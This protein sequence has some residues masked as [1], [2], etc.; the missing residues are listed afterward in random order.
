MKQGPEQRPTPP[1]SDVS[2][3][4]RGAEVSHTER[5]SEGAEMDRGSLSR[6]IVAL[7]NGETRPREPVS[8]EGSGRVMGASSETRRGPEPLESVSTRRRRIEQVAQQHPNEPL[9]A[10]NHHLD[11]NWLHEEVRKVYS[12]DK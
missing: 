2:E 10:L 11:L 4:S 5:P 6:R 8:S 9:T 12:Q 7:E 1:R 3:N